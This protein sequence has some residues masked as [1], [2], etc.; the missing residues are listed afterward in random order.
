MAGALS[1]DLCLSGLNTHK[2]SLVPLTVLYVISSAPLICGGYSLCPC[3]SKIKLKQHIIDKSDNV[4][5]FV[6]F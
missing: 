1:V 5:I 4:F 6:V 3:A 2:F